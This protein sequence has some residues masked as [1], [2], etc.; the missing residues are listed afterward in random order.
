M[1]GEFGLVKKNFLMEKN[2]HHGDKIN[3][4]KLLKRPKSKKWL[5]KIYIKNNIKYKKNDFFNTKTQYFFN[6]AG[7]VSRELKA[8][9][10]GF[11]LFKKWVITKK[12]WVF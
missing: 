10:T 2:K 8:L 7:A 11:F 6:G 4:Q 12:L 1:K 3:F 5:K 9:P